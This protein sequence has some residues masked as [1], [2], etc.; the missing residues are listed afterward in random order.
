MNFQ[1]RVKTKVNP[2]T[3]T[4]NTEIITAGFTLDVFVDVFTCTFWS[5]FLSVFGLTK[6]ELFS[7]DELLVE[8]SE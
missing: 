5:V 3:V 1:K 6:D 2:K 7:D 4:Q 8:E